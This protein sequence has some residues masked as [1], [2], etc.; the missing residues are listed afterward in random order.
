MPVGAIATKCVLGEVRT[1]GDRERRGM[2]DGSARVPEV[3][4]AAELEGFFAGF[5]TEPLEPAL[6]A[7]MGE[8]V[9]EA[10]ELA[11]DAPGG[12]DD[13]RQEGVGD[14]RPR[15]VGLPVAVHLGTRCGL[16]ELVGL[17]MP[18]R[19]V[20][21]D[22]GHVIAAE[23]VDEGNIND[24]VGVSADVGAL[25]DQVTLSGL[26]FLF[27]KRSQ[28]GSEHH[29]FVAIF[30]TNFFSVLK[31]MTKIYIIFRGHIS[32]IHGSVSSPEIV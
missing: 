24:E 17:G 8:N 9:E 31:V 4:S 7:P 12:A 14:T 6:G 20:E 25:D 5:V 26:A 32:E 21:A 16:E 29:K 30:Q 13:T 22:I 2:A 23:L 18:E 15:G 10:Q 3:L 19:S 28:S 27:L 1:A 11:V